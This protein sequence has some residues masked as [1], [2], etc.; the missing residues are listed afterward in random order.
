MANVVIYDIQTNRV[1]RY[2]KSVNT[3]DYDTRPDVIVNPSLPDV[4]LK[5]MK[6][7]N[8][9]VVEMSQ[10]EKDIV[11]YEEQVAANAVIEQN[12]DDLTITIKD[13]FTAFIKVYN[14]KVPV[15]YQITKAELVQQLK[16][17][18]LT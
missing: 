6:I 12:A 4:A 3:P 10:A 14:S 7:N 13:A 11:L 5:F 15:Q 18:L 17:D 9:Q 1:L 2:L 16:D 8:G